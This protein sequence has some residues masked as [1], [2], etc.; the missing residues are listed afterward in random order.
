M[1]GGENE[2]QGIKTAEN[3]LCGLAGSRENSGIMFRSDAFK[4]SAFVVLAV[5]TGA[6][7]APPLYW[8]GKSVVASGILL[9]GPLAGVH[10]SM[11]RAQITRY[12]NRSLQFSALLL[13][14]PFT[15]WIGV[16]RGSNWLLLEKNP[17]RWTHLGAGFGLAAGAL[18]LLGWIY[19]EIGYYRG[20]DSGKPL[21]RLLLS[22]MGTGMSVALLEEFLFRGALFGLILRTARPLPALV[23]LSAFFAIVHFLKPP[24]NLELPP[25]VWHTG[26]W[27]TGQIFGQFGDLKFLAAEF[28]L[29]FCVGWVLGYARLK[30]S[31]LW[32]SIGLH[33][34]WVFG[35]KLYSGLTRKALAIAEMMPWAG[36]SLRVGIW[37]VA[38]VALTGMFLWWWLRRR[39]P[40]SAFA[41]IERAQDPTENRTA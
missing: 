38:V 3:S 39:Y 9:D 25:V 23:F 24:D 35:I 34:G 13:A 29:L 14:Y 22:A 20:H 19:V 1:S 4:I 26:F 2:F 5:V 12:F 30:T 18:L 37:S 28:T 33:A 6:L 8:F 15:R 16:R 21:H 27:L 36:P 32:L 40:R 41:P 17:R 7:L 11:E 31:S 10:E